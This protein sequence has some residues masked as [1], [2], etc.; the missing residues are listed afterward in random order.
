MFGKFAT[1]LVGYT[2]ASIVHEFAQR[3]VVKEDD[4]AFP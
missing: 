3:L 4:A 2:H 1:K